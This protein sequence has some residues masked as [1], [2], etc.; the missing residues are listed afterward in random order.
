[1]KTPVLVGVLLLALGIGVFAYQ[2]VTYKSRDTVVD[3]G[4]IK[5]T[6]ERERT[7]P[8]SPMLGVTALIAGTVLV[9]IG[10]RKRPVF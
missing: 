5:A 9:I 7:L 8:L 6:V 3:V 10:L 2:G 4:P 1:M